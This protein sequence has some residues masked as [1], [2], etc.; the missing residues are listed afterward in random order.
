MI[1]RIN[2]KG[3]ITG[4]IGNF[5]E[6]LIGYHPWSIGSEK[7]VRIPCFGAEN[8]DQLRQEASDAGFVVPD[9]LTAADMQKIVKVQTAADNRGALTSTGY[10]FTWSEVGDNYGSI[11][12]GSQYSTNANPGLIP[13]PDIVDFSFG[14]NNLSFVTKS[15]TLYSCGNTEGGATGLPMAFL[16]LAKNKMKIFKPLSV[17]TNYEKFIED[18]KHAT[19]AF[20]SNGQAPIVQQKE[21]DPNINTDILNNE[22]YAYK[23]RKPLKKIDLSQFQN[24]DFQTKKITPNREVDSYSHEFM[25]LTGSDLIANIVQ[26]VNW[27]GV[28]GKEGAIDPM[29][30]LHQDKLVSTLPKFTTVASGFA[31]TLVLDED[32]HAWAHGR[33]AHGELGHTLDPFTLEGRGDVKQHN[34]VNTGLKPVDFRTYYFPMKV[35]ALQDVK[36]SKIS[37]GLHHSAVLSK[38]GDVYTFGSNDFGQCGRLNE[39]PSTLRSVTLGHKQP[40]SLPPGK[41]YISPNVLNGAKVVDVVCGFYDT[42]LTLSDG[43]CLI[44]GGYLSKEGQPRRIFS[45]KE[46]DPSGVSLDTQ[47]E[48][49]GDETGSEGYSESESSGDEFVKNEFIQVIPSREMVPR[50]IYAETNRIEKENIDNG[51]RKMS[52]IY[53]NE[54]YSLKSITFGWQHV[55]AIATPRNKAKG[56]EMGSFDQDI[57][58]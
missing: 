23:M 44:A 35:E 36:L 51:E 26:F 14:Y 52:N 31:H 19:R 58:L 10:L 24:R 55:L 41:L 25:R 16:N 22:E 15:G 48:S 46:F 5:V 37:A 28:E 45:L 13:I 8:D 34:I 57:K 30:L 39:L 3:K 4:I 2:S 43:R 33:N 11:G 12:Q 47:N 32:G 7:L 1:H 21:S 53:T 9:W 29:N 49:E 42:A 17:H 40:W 38:D 27:R 6:D 20:T 50:S 54:A 18:L 56:V